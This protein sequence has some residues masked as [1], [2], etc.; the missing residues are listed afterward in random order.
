M[1]TKEVDSE[2]LFQVCIRVLRKVKQEL[3]SVQLIRYNVFKEAVIE[4]MQLKKGNIPDVLFK[5]TLVIEY[6]Q[7]IMA[8]LPDEG[9]TEYGK[10]KE[11]CQNRASIRARRLGRDWPAAKRKAVYEGLV[12]SALCQEGVLCKHLHAYLGTAL[13]PRI[14]VSGDIE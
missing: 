12:H 8:Q 3:S 13:S 11:I 4:A 14:V 5:K 2:L 10:L 9:R 1:L 6:F 7:F